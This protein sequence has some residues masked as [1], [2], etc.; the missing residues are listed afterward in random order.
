MVGFGHF[1]QVT[2]CISSVAPVIIL[3]DD[4]RE[5]GDSVI[6]LGMSKRCHW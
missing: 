1:K 6:V 4:I 5:V 2:Y 3:K